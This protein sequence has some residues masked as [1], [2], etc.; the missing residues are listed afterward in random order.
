[1]KSK[2]FN[3]SL[4]SPSSRTTLPLFMGTAGFAAFSSSTNGYGYSPPSA[5]LVWDKHLKVCLL[6]TYESLI[7]NKKRPLKR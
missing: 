6:C 4:C 2:L 7:T 1:M 5:T 3:Y